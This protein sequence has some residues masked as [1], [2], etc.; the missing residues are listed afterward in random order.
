M[1]INSEPPAD[2]GPAAMRAKRTRAQRSRELCLPYLAN[3]MMRVSRR[4]SLER[5]RKPNLM[6]LIH[7]GLTTTT[8]EHAMAMSP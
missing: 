5:G 3:V 4:A 6:M 1:D 8:L 2:F 7:R